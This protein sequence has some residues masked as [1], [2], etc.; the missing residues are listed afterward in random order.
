LVG[1]KIYLSE[2]IKRRVNNKAKLTVKG[3]TNLLKGEGLFDEAGS[4]FLVEEF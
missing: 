3:R 4:Y 1:K 2:K